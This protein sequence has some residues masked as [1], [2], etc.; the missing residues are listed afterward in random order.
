M[1]YNEMITR[2]GEIEVQLLECEK[3]SEILKEEREDLI[4]AVFKQKGYNP[5]I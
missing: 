1:E 2:L 4:E 5:E 3:Y